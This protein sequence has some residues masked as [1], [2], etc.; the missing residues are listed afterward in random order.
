[1]DW[2]KLSGWTFSVKT[3][4]KGLWAQKES[5]STRRV[6]KGRGAIKGDFFVLP[7]GL[8]FGFFVE[9]GRKVYDDMYKKIGS[10]MAS[11]FCIVILFNFCRLSRTS[12]K[13]IRK[14]SIVTIEKKR[15]EIGHL[16]HS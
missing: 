12:V 16:S 10:W 4:N 11:C 1:M 15:E 7:V 5:K 14:F 3:Y 8:K 6:Y 9:Q 2:Q 13:L